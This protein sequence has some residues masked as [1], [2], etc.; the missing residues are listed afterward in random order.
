MAL[1]AIVLLGVTGALDWRTIEARS[2]WGVLL[3]FGGGITLGTLMDSSG[4]S[5]MMAS[6]LERILPGGSGWWQTW[7]FYL[8]IA[9]FVVMLTEL[10]SNTASTALLVPVLSAVALT[11]GASDTSVVV[12]IAICASCAFMLPVATPPNALVYGTGDV[13]QQAM[14]RAGLR[15]NLL[16][17]LLL[18][19]LAGT[20]VPLL[21]ASS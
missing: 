8:L 11:L 2:N 20:L 7:L 9:L 3:L 5:L 21:I 19:T 13:P 6:A 12:L 18:G 1:L 16:C 15:L 4:T 17:A 14:I 10:V